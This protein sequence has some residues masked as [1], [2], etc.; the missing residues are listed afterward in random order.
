MVSGRFFSLGTV[1]SSVPVAFEL[2]LN[3][4]SNSKNFNMMT[5]RKTQREASIGFAVGQVSDSG[6]A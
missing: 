6:E 4:Y 5:Y 2:R 1:I 3:L